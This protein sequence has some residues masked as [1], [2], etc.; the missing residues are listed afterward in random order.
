MQDRLLTEV[1]EVITEL[2]SGRLEARVRLPG[3]D[4]DD[5][6]TAIAVGLNM[7]AEELQALAAG[8]EL[9]VDARTQELRATQARLSY[10]A[11]H[12]HLTGLG[13]RRL[14]HHRLEHQLVRD[15]GNAALLLLDLDGF[16]DVNDSLGHGV[17]DEVLVEVAERLRSCL[18]PNDVIARLGGDEFAALLLE[19]RERGLDVIGDRVCRALA[20]PITVEG[21][22]FGMSA[23]VGLVPLRAAGT[24]EVL[25]RLADLAM[26]QA[27][28]GGKNRFEV[29]RDEL[30][31]QAQ[32]KRDMERGLRSALDAGRIAVVYQPLIDARSGQLVGAEA[33]SRWPH[34]SGPVFS[35][36]T[37]IPV[38]ERT[39]LIHE[40]GRAVLHTACTDAVRWAEHTG[41]LLPVSVNVSGEQLRAPDF[42]E[43]VLD[44][45]A[46]TG[47]TPAMI[48]LEVTETV[49]MDQQHGLGSL[50]VLREAGLRVAI[51]DFGTGFSSLAALRQLPVDTLKIDRSFVAGIGTDDDDGTVIR[52]IL[53]L[54]R[55]LRLA[56]VAE[57]V[58]TPPQRDELV[59]LGCHV[60]Q[61]YLFGRPMPRMEFQSWAEGRGWAPDDQSPR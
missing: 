36:D 56:V 3:P 51:D 55:G 18:R 9:A 50:T 43:R 60:H 6:L 35:P 5:E 58:E 12:D 49:V 14:M 2:A 10:D 31:Q 24:A 13:N 44:V 19:V 41:H 20:E 1:L 57:G 30:Q 37:F 7:L 61:G 47:A 8:L 46:E 23:S 42:P 33:L 29:Y 38:A 48:V 26:Y 15:H 39:G 21:V 52:A 40:L 45:L 4:R 32:Q 28:A 27:K 59:A 11:T 25:L 16:K 53:G 54:A 22:A 17:G 34:A